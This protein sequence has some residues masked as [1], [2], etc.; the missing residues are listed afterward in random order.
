MCA[1]YID[2][3]GKATHWWLQNKI[4][5]VIV[6]PT[7]EQY[8]PDKPPYHLGRGSGFLT[9]KPSKRAQ[10]VI[11]RVNESRRMV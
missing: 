5:N 4:T 1:S 10:I 9:K 8:L 3:G 7:K 11:N 2:E 6:D